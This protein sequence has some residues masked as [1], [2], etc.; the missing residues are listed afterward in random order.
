MQ[1]QS[2]YR[3]QISFPNGELKFYSIP[4][5]S[6]D[7]CIPKLFHEEIEIKYF[8]EGSSTLLIGEDIIIT[9][10]GDI[11]ICNPHEIQSTLETGNLTGKYHLLLMDPDIFTDAGIQNFDLR[12][13]LVGKQIQFH[14]LIRGNHTLEQLLLRIIQDPAP[15]TPYYRHRMLGLLLELFSYLADF[16]SDTIRKE[17]LFEQ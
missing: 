16:E 12:H 2:S 4:H 5:K 15:R 3:E 14:H 8:Y 9:Q 1:T 11:V 6:S 7:T 17:P 10:P 13:L